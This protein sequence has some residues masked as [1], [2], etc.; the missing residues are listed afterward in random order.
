[1]IFLKLRINLAKNR[2][3]STKKI[4]HIIIAFHRGQRSQFKWSYLFKNKSDQ[5]NKNSDR[6]V[7]TRSLQWYFTLPI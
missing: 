2:S 4:I 1:M 7:R 5:K 3:G 6:F